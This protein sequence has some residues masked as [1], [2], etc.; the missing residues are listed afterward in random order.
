MIN[1]D[2]VRVPLDSDERRRSFI[3][4]SQINSMYK[5]FTI[6]LWPAYAFR[7]RGAVSLT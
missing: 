5:C 7:V 2:V 1:S 3:I 6:I 4:L